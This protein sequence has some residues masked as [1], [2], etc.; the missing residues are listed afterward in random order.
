ME[1]EDKPPPHVS[2]R[3]AGLIGCR[4][5]EKL[6]GDGGWG[7]KCLGDDAGRG[8]VLSRSEVGLVRS[9]TGQAA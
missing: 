2:E 1:R 4:V 7:A 8:V 9:T 6:F 3:R 5:C